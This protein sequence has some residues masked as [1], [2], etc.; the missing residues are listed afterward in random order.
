MG[1]D[2]A[3]TGT[4][5][6]A[7]TSPVLQPN[8]R[9][10]PAMATHKR[11]HAAPTAMAGA[12]AIDPA[13]VGASSPVVATPAGSTSIPFAW[14]DLAPFLYLAP[15]LLLCGVMALAVVRL[16]AMRGRAEILAEGS[17]LS[18]LADAQWRMGFKH[19]TALLV[20][21]DVGNIVWRVTPK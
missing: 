6:N 4:Q 8:Q 18:A 21:D 2:A 13:V 15:L 9:R 19:G 7:K 5:S 20:S 3:P 11:A 16:F 12:P 10:C 17:W 1:S 14:S